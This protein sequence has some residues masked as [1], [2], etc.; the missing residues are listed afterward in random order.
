MDGIVWLYTNSVADDVG[1]GKNPY[2]EN[3]RIC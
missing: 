1:E 2:G 3:E